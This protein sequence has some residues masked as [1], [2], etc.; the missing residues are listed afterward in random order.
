MDWRK[1]FDALFIQLMKKKFKEC[2]GQLRHMNLKWIIDFI[3]FENNLLDMSA[4]WTQI[5]S[6]TKSNN[7]CFIKKIEDLANIDSNWGFE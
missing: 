1:K 7:L 4:L 6:E 2:L 3:C 5:G